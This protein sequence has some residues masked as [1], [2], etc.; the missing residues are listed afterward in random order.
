MNLRKKLVGL[1]AFSDS[2]V[3][4]VRLEKTI[5]IQSPTMHPD[6]NKKPRQGIPI[7]PPL[8]KRSVAKRSEAKRSEE[9]S[10]ATR[11]V[12]KRSEA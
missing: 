6:P 2:A 11:G 9:R 1:V 10:E 8:A 3:L 4:A 7:G 5:E 12:A